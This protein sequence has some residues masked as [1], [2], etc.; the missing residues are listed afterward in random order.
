MSEKKR[1]ARQNVSKNSTKEGR[2]R[3]RV[4]LREERTRRGFSLQDI[5]IRTNIPLPF[6]EALET[7]IVPQHLRG[8]K[9]GQYKRSSNFFDS[10]T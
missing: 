10:D 3:V 4:N 6:L 8:R 9:L 1:R 2:K 7:G 5:S